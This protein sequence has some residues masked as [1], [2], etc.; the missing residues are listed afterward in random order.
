MDICSQNVTGRNFIHWLKLYRWRWNSLTERDKLLT[1]LHRIS[2]TGKLVGLLWLK[3]WNIPLDKITQIH[4]L[5]E[6]H[7]VKLHRILLDKSSHEEN[8]FSQDNSVSYTGNLA[9]LLYVR[10]WNIPT[11][12]TS[13][14][15]TEY[16]FTKCH[17][18]KLLGITLARF[19]Q[20]E[21]EFIQNPT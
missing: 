21:I 17:C 5:I 16:F 10:S 15:F 4:F 3:P 2:R 7:W 9:G 6:C 8:T 20:K 19:S 12:N 1:K 18:M 13:Q 11:G 14:N